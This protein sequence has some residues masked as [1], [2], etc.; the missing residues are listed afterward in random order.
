MAAAAGIF[1][2]AWWLQPFSV[3]GLSAFQSRAVN[4][5]ADALRAEVARLQQQIE[6]LRTGAVQPESALAIER[7]AREQLAS[8]LK[9]AQDDN[10]RLKD[11]LAMYEEITSAARR[12]D[13]AV[14][15]TRLKVE[16]GE[17]AGQFRY[18]MLV[19]AP[20]AG[21]RDAKFSGT[22]QL[23]VNIFH[24]G[25]NAIM[26]IPAASDPDRSSYTLNFKH[27]QRIEGEFAVP[28]GA[29][30]TSVEVRVLQGG[31]IRAKSSI[32]L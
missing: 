3:P 4:A 12:G 30:P 19:A 27:F 29:R 1:A 17:S 26:S 7:A 28:A 23:L 6:E 8:Q 9:A 21:G 25:R 24:E 16:A 11:D 31:Q 18:R 14:S 22:Y 5:E 2:L 13:A 20:A 10:A 15:I 32:K